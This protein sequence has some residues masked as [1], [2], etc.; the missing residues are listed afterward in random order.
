[1]VQ[2]KS[3]KS[4]IVLIQSIFLSYLDYLEKNALKKKDISLKSD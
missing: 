3:I 4:S 2:D 1:M